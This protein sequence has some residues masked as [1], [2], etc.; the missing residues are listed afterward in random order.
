MNYKF[1][2]C[3]IEYWQAAKRLE[4]LADALPGTPEAQERKELI[5]L[6]REFE[7]DIQGKKKNYR[8]SKTGRFKLIELSR[9]G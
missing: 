5:R 9:L 8:L 3:R 2:G 7:Q 1:L 6:F 4:E